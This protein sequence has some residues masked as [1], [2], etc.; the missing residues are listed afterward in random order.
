MIRPRPFA[1]LALALACGLALTSVLAACD[2]NVEQDAFFLDSE[3][4]PEGFTRTADGGAVDSSHVDPDDW[5]VGPAFAGA[6]RVEPAWPNPVGR[7]GL[8]TLVVTDVFGDAI[9]GGLRLQGITNTAPRQFVELDRDD[10]AGPVYV[11]TFDPTRLRLTAGDDAQLFRVR[12]FTQ[13]AALI[14][15]G[16]VLVQ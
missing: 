12:V 13:D 2:T 8:V 6:V 15:Y 14:T 9:V 10:S 11:F 3:R 7:N 4:P 1:V 16:D 5:R